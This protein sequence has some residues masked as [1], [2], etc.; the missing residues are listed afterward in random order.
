MNSK[1]RRI[2]LTAKVGP[3]STYPGT[4]R[5]AAK[6][7][8]VGDVVAVKVKGR[9]TVGIIK[10]TGLVEQQQNSIPM[11]ETLKITYVERPIFEIYINPFKSYFFLE[12]NLRHIDID[13]DVARQIVNSY[14][15]VLEE[16]SY[17]KDN[18]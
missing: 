5:M 12:E 13:P 17:E 4:F 2:D 3:A 16:V 18:I 11:S 14:G 6:A 8:T 10:S 1:D 9:S 15:G 7:F